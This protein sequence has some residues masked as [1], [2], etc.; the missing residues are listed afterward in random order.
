MNDFGR[1]TVTGCGMNLGLQLQLQQRELKGAACLES[2]REYNRAH[3]RVVFTR[4]LSAQCWEET[5][6]AA[7]QC[8]SRMQVMLY[9]NTPT[10][11]KTPD[12]C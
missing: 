7:V 1:L 3:F 2:L 12:L 4:P 8:H 10:A 11:P 5:A 6:F 9:P